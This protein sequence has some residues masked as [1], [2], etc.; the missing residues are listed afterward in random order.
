MSIFEFFVCM[1]RI[2][3]CWLKFFL[4]IHWALVQVW[5]G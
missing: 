4:C 3:G 5:L 1:S 2:I